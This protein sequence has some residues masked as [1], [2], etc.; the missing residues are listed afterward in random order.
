MATE[1]AGRSVAQLVCLALGVGVVASG[2]LGVAL[3]LETD[4]W[5]DAL[6]LVSGAALAVAALSRGSAPRA[7][8]A[9]GAFY[10][11][12]AI[13]GFVDRQETLGLIAINPVDNLL[14]AGLAVAALAAGIVSRPRA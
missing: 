2:L 11:A 7:L 12:V 8:V 9:F 5:H 13:T 10:A 4:R 1:I 14:H 6:H 3:V